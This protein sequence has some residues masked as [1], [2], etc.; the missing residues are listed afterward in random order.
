MHSQPSLFGAGLSAIAVFTGMLRL[1]HTQGGCGVF[2]LNGQKPPRLGRSN[3][4][5]RRAAAS[6]PGGGFKYEILNDKC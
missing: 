6:T 5:M 4:C 3:A 1:L 2:C